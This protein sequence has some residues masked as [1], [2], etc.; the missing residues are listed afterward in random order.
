MSRSRQCRPWL[1]RGSILRRRLIARIYA[2]NVVVYLA[3]AFFRGS[4]RFF[5]FRKIFFYYVQLFRMGSDFKFLFMQRVPR[6]LKRILR[7]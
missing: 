7:T 4:Q 1:K 6:F 2:G 5:S 3:L